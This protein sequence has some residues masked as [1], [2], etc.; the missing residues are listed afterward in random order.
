M[1]GGAILANIIPPRRHGQRNNMA[2]DLWPNVKLNTFESK[3]SLFVHDDSAPLKRRQV[4]SGTYPLLYRG[5]IVHFIPLKKKKKMKKK[6]MVGS[7]CKLYASRWC[8]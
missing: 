2:S 4:P 6:K 3:L 1:C 7:E 5:R 8:A